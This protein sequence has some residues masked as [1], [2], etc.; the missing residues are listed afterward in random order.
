[1]NDLAYNDCLFFNYRIL[2]I[3]EVK[4]YLLSLLIIEDL[5]NMINNQNNQNMEDVR[6][7]LTEETLNNLPKTIYSD[8]NHELKNINNYCSVCRDIYSETDN[9]ELRILKC[10]HVFCCECID[11]WLLNHSHKCP[12]CRIEMDGHIHV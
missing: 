7:V 10:N 9:K 8:I 11:P 5:T 12:N 4:T 6:C 2:V 3:E 1:M